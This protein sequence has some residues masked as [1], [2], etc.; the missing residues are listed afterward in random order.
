MVCFFYYPNHILGYIKICWV[1][2][3]IVELFLVTAQKLVPAL[4][5]KILTVW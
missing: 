3:Y 2:F 5:V 1:I 4:M